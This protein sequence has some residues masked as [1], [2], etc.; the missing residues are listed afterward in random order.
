TRLAF[1]LSRRDFGCGP[2]PHAPPRR[3][4]QTE[5]VPPLIQ[6]RTVEPEYGIARHTSRHRYALRQRIDDRTAI[7]NSDARNQVPQRHRVSRTRVLE[8]VR[9]RRLVPL[10]P[11]TAV[12]E[13]QLVMK[14]LTRIVVARR[15]RA[16][17]GIH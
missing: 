1:S 17:H 6:R 13:I 5:R 9:E 2:L 3:V 10:R 4:E 14:P 8:D 11:R 15:T 16:A 12:H 7:A